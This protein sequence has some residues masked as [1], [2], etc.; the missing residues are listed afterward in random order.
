MMMLTHKSDTRCQITKI[1]FLIFLS[2]IA[3]TPLPASERYS[4]ATPWADLKKTISSTKYAEYMH[5]VE[6]EKN[7]YIRPSD[8]PKSIDNIEQLVKDCQH[9]T[10]RGTLNDNVKCA[11]GKCTK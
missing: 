6:V 8:H 2:R 11:D 5:D 1:L 3:S 7:A 9:Y 4:S 10:S